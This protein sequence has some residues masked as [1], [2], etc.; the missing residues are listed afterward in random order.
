MPTDTT[1]PR[2]TREARLTRSLNAAL[3]QQRQAHL[4]HPLPTLAERKADL[5]QLR[6]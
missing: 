3:R 1:A 4:A 5:L 2:Q 6:R